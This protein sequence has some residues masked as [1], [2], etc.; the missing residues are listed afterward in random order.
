MEAE[1]FYV[2]VYKKNGQAV[3]HIISPDGEFKDDMDEQKLELD[4][5]NEL[6]NK[7]SEE[8]LS[9]FNSFCTSMLSYVE[10]LPFVASI[11]PFMSYSIRS[12]EFLNFLNDNSVISEETDAKTV[13]KMKSR[14]WKECSEISESAVKASEVGQQIPKM[15]MIGIVSSYEHHLARLIK[16]ILLDNPSKLASS[17]RQISVKEVFDLSDILNFKEMILEKE[18]DLAM[19]NSFEE[20]ISWVEKAV[21]IKKEIKSEYGD[22]PKVVEIFERRNLF[23]HTN[24]VVNDRYLKKASKLKFSGHSKFSK[25][26]ELLTNPKY[27][28]SSLETILEFGVKLIQVIW[29]KVDKPSKIMQDDS[30]GDIA[31]E[32]IERGYYSLAI[33]ILEF[34]FFLDGA[35]REE[36]RLVCLVNLANAYKLIG[37]NNKARQLLDAEDF[38]VVSDVFRIC[39]ASV[40]E[41][42][43]EVVRLLKKMGAECEF[44]ERAYEEWPVFFHVRDDVAFQA[45]FAEVFKRDFVPAPKKRRGV[46]QSVAKGSEKKADSRNKNR[47]Q[48][49]PLIVVENRLD[50]V[51]APGG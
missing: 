24:G 21:G 32:M 15:L 51:D 4:H 26:Q 37:D 20:Q 5:E 1:F 31:F 7:S 17:E 18:I 25:G 35:K 14:Y 19:R 47:L 43:G 27:F 29:R 50:V 12:G 9:I 33:K 46:V 45:A 44:G 48:G 2:C 13:F 36:R 11:S 39:V 30:L 10:I 8:Y 28:R 49:E 40:R 41:E 23:T 16:R 42:V 3:G 38:S 34:F 6:K 22:W